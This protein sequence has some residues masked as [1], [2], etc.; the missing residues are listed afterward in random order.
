MPL[1]SLCA[2][3]RVAVVCGG[4]G[5]LIVLRPVWLASLIAVASDP[6]HHVFGE[7]AQLCK[8]LLREQQDLKEVIARQV[9]LAVGLLSR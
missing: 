1:C 2:W 8:D 3:E 4:C 5:L 7:L 9:R 6:Q